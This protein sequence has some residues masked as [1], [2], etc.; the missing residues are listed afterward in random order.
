VTGSKD[1][2]VRLWDLTAKDQEADPEVLRGHAGAVVAMEISPDNHW[3][4]TGSDD[5]T[6]RLWDL[7]APWC[8]AA[9]RAR[10]L[11]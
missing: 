8:C 3:L 11:R 6:V 1:Y 4:V 2:T 9:M 5:N 7:T 10:S